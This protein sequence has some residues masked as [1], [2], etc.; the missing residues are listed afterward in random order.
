MDDDT[1]EKFHA[2]AVMRIG[3]G[4]KFLQVGVTI[5]VGIKRGVRGV[6]WH[7]AIGDLPIVPDAIGIGVT[8]NGEIEAGGVVHGEWIVFGSVGTGKNGDITDR[9]GL[10]G[11]LNQSGGACGQSAQITDNSV[12]RVGTTALAGNG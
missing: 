7:G 10:E 12:P 6:I 5:S 3:A 1:G 4:V 11:D 8:I 9:A 2:V